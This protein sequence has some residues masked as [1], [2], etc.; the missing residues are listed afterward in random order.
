MSAPHIPTVAWTW[1]IGAPWETPYIV[2]YASNLDDGPAHGIPLGGL[3]AGC[4]GRAPNGTFNLWHL[5]GGEHTFEQ[6][7]ACRFVVYEET[8]GETLTYAMATEGTGLSQW[9]WYPAS[10]QAYRP[11]A[12]EM[13]QGGTYKALY[14]RSW[15]TYRD[16]FKAELTCEQFSPIWP[17]N[18]RESS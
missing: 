14:P 15:Y 3:G 1:P 10:R 18:Y 4:I 6:F 16:I 13:G 12:G 8:A 5:D 2:R 7:P 11:G 9:Q 17:E